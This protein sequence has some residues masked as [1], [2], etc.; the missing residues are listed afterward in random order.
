MTFTAASLAYVSVVGLPVSI[1]A[2][3]QERQSAYTGDRE[4]PDRP[5]V[6]A[7]IEDRERSEATLAG[8]SAVELGLLSP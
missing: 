6:N 5:I 8:R 2:K 3:W 1:Q 7:P 4:H